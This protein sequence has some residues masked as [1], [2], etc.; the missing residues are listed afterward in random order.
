MEP[1]HLVIAVAVTRYGSGTDGFSSLDIVQ[2]ASFQKMTQ[3]K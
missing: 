2:M 1:H 3:T